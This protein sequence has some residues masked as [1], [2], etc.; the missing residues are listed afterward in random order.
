MLSQN[1]DFTYRGTIIFQLYR[2]GQFYWWRKPEKTT[3]LPQVT[4]KLYRIMLY[5]VHL[6]WVGF[7]FTMLVIIGSFKSK[8]FSCIGY[9]LNGKRIM[10]NNATCMRIWRV[11]F[12]N[13]FGESFICSM[14]EFKSDSVFYFILFNA[15]I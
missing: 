11:R 9:L 7:E 1:L 2:G 10:E 4:D 6:A 15:T 8:D 3:N 12:E 5:R 14:Y 13:I